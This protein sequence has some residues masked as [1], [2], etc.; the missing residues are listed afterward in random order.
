[1]RIQTKLKAGKYLVKASLN[2]ENGRIWIKFPFNRILLAEVK[3]MKGA[4]WHGFDEPPRKVWSVI[5]CPRNQFQLDY[6][7]KKNPYA[8]Y[9]AP[10]SMEVESK[11]PLYEHQLLMTAHAL[12]R[13][14]CI[15][16][17]EMGT[18]KTLAA[19]EVMEKA[20]L[21]NHE[22]WYVGPKS[23]IRAV[24]LELDKWQSRVQPRMFTYRGLV[25][26]MR[27][28][29][30]TA[31]RLVIFDESSKIKTPT[32]Q[33]SQAAMY[34]ADAI[35]EE[36]GED[37]Y[38]ILMSGTPAPKTPVDWWHQCEVACPGFL[39]EGQVNK[40]KK[41]LCIIEERQSI[42]GG[43][44]P[45]IV[46]WL[47][48]ENRCA[49]CGQY[50]THE[51]HWVDGDH[52]FVKSKNEV[53]RLYRRLKG[54][55]LVLFKKDCLDLPEKQYKIIRVKATPSIIRTAKLIA[56]TSRRAIEALTLCRELSDG[57]QYTEEAIG[58][59]ECPVCHG[60]G[61]AMVKIPK[62]D[63]DA[64]QPL[65]VNSDDFIEKKMICDTCG[66]A[67]T[68]KKF[69]RSTDDVT[70][71]KDDVLLEIMDDHSE[72]GRLIV[73][74]GFTATI[75]RLVDIATKH[76]WSVL[77]IDGRGYYGVDADGHTLDANELL[78]AMDASHPRRK[79]LEETYPK[80]CV[81]GNAKAGGYAL[82]LTASPTEVFY[83]NSFDGEARM[84]AED[85]FHRAGMDTNRGATIIDLILLPTDQLVLD[86]LK[87]KKRLQDLSMGELNAALSDDKE[88][89]N[90]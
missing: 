5:D 59:E 61:E 23:G 25:T 83:S 21:Q 87:K 32:S 46:A 85:R 22:A 73:W 28:Y 44:Y 64:M 65:D 77:R 71:P 72:V 11:R 33:R 66:G 24:N 86:N 9:D 45:H 51:R 29:S 47:D 60:V 35:R 40:F 7:Q 6:L 17:C 39:K 30:G 38:V 36:H 62:N 12:T 13:H 41:S 43:V 49:I 68:V 31:P 67:G 57:F 50:E 69:A 1:M 63:V 42:T 10:L 84:Q 37:G 55:A 3:A 20:G 15:F 4:R 16:A 18:G 78:I 75:D 82:T 81:V 54:L 34:L 80:L 19:I 89:I 70:S 27:S 90:V 53:E 52:G 26:H 2:Y 56:K 76:G 8:R 58:T 14:Y 88:L 74:G 48:D 79:E